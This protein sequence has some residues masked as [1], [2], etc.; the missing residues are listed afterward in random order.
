M[1]QTRISKRMKIKVGM[2]TRR[3]VRVKL[4]ILK[5]VSLF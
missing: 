4:L 1:K 2:W 5:K 3:K